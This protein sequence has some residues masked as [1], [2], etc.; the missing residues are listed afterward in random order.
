MI[1]KCPVFCQNENFVNISK[2]LLKN[3]LNFSRSALFHMKTNDQVFGV[4]Q[5]IKFDLKRPWVGER[6]LCKFPSLC[7]RFYPFWGNFFKD[8]FI[9]LIICWQTSIPGWES[10]KCLYLLKPCCKLYFPSLN[11]IYLIFEGNGR[12]SKVM[13][14]NDNLWAFLKSHY[15][16]SGN[17][18]KKSNFDLSKN[19]E[20]TFS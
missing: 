2:K 20:C 18:W 16:C 15:L 14:G 13:E 7:L 19:H 3:K 6:T 8:L 12:K 4:I 9:W 11:L 10:G 1:A 17:L 5:H